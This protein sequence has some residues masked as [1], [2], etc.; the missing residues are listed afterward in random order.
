MVMEI[1]ILVWD[2][3]H[4]L[5]PDRTMQKGNIANAKNYVKK[6]KENIMEDLIKV[7]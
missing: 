6:E 3:D 2:V 7:L 4:F 5:T 1:V